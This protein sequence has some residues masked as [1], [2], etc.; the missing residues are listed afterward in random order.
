MFEAEQRVYDT[1]KSKWLQ[2]HS[3]EFA[4]IKG[5]QLIGFYPDYE[6]AFRGGL[7]QFGLASSFFIKQVCDQEPVFTIY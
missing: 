6:S 3:G 4:V 5:E 1:S 7:Q 2:E